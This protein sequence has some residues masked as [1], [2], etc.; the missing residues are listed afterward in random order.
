M[1]TSQGNEEPDTTGSGDQEGSRRSRNNNRNTKNQGNKKFKNRGNRPKIKGDLEDLGYNVYIT[2]S[3]HQVDMYST[4]TKAIADY[5]GKE[6][7]AVMRTLVNTSVETIFTKP[8]KPEPDEDEEKVDPLD[9]EEW[10]TK[11]N[12]YYKKLDKYE[13]DKAR[14]YVIIKGQCTTAVTN[15][16]EAHSEYR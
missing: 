2:G 12:C 16:V 13:E 10:K 9:I 3:I 1:P 4:T 11:L 5:V 14:A 6:F 7:G 8:R 15:K